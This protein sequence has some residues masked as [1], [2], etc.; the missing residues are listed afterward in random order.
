[1][2][3]PSPFLVPALRGVFECELYAVWTGNV[4]SD[5][6][7]PCKNDAS[8]IRRVCLPSVKKDHPA[9]KAFSLIPV[10]I[11]PS[12]G[13]DISLDPRRLQPILLILGCAFANEVSRF[14]RGHPSS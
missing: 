2:I 4:V 14:H 8:E 6:L 1:M 9:Y 7:L 5:N 11:P 10:K 13:V 12:G 3:L